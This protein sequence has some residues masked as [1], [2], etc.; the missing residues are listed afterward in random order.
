MKLN[1]FLALYTLI[2]GFGVY[3]VLVDKNGYSSFGAALM[4]LAQAA[5]AVVVLLIAIMWDRANWR[6]YLWALL[7]VC[8]PPLSIWIKDL[9]LFETQEPV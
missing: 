9:H 1:I 3:V 7:W 5:A 8:L 4:L 2:A 6:R